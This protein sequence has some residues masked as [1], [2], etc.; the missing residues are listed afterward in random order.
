MDCADYIW[1]PKCAISRLQNESL[2]F[3]SIMME[4][5]KLLQIITNINILPSKNVKV[6]NIFRK[7][8]EVVP[9]IN[10]KNY[11]Q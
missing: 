10:I 11:A 1:H 9:N 2:P 5:N 4:C 8:H 3:N 6:Q 7:K